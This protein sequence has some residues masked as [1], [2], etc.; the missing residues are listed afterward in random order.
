MREITDEELA[1]ALRAAEDEQG[2]DQ[3]LV[4][5]TAAMT[6]EQR[7]QSEENLRRWIEA[8]RCGREATRA[9]RSRV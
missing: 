7:R 8:A 6:A 4:R 5:A 2:V 3:R 9:E 1:A